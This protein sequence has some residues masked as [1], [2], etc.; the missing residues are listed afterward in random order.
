MI[1]CCL[2][3]TESQKFSSKQISIAFWNH[4]NLEVNSFLCD[5]IKTE[6]AFLFHRNEVGVGI[7]DFDNVLLAFQQS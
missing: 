3:L 4:G 2:V 7:I 1:S 5:Y 6:Y